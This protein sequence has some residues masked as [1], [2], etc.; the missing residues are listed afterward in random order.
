[1][2]HPIG[3]VEGEK[4]VKLKGVVI[5]VLL[6]S[7]A[8][9]FWSVYSHR[10]RVFP[11]S[12]LRTLYVLSNEDGNS[13]G[14][15]VVPSRSEALRR[16]T[17]IPYITASFDPDHEKAGVVSAKL[18][19]AFRGVSLYNSR[20]A[21]SAQLIDMAGAVIH[22]WSYET[23]DGWHLTEL[24]PN[25]DLLVIDKG[26]QLIRLNV[27]SELLWAYKGRPHHAL[28]VFEEK[29]YVLD[30][31][32]AIRPEID[33]AR[34]TL[35]DY[36]SILGLDGIE[37]ERVS[38]LDLLLS[39]PYAFLLPSLD[40]SAREGDKREHLHLP[41]GE[42]L[43]ILHTNHIELFDGRHA[44]RSP[45]FERGNVL[46]SLRNLNAI[47]ILDKSMR[48]ILW[49]WGPG[50]LIF[51]HHPQ[52]LDN[53][54][55]LIFDNGNERSRILEI[56]PVNLDIVWSYEADDF[57]SEARGSA[58]RLPNGNTLITESDSGWVFEV[59]REGRIVWSFANPD[60]DESG[61][62]GAIYRM[63]RYAPEDLPFLG[64][65]DR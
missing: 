13:P 3:E 63:T 43:D 5:L 64:G 22:E 52:L 53:G 41:G 60:V 20:R 45:I 59:D 9:F 37:V 10:N 16:L 42:S 21:K 30:R 23:A 44:D 40:P 31:S 19:R 28:D 24:L 36:I 1:M 29:I 50:N 18:D 47:L 62:R 35:I 51:Q 46:L 6:A 7:G 61:N 56:D 17:A 34:P 27:K 33:E 54:N 11:Y 15:Q 25:G 55:L 26:T 57:F 49:L 38:I 48:E 8:S 65:E 2:G 58:Q 4:A 14:P 39:S 32:E 12:L